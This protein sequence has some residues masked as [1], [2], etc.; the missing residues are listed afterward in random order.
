MKPF[1]PFIV[2]SLVLLA[3]W[4]IYAF[5]LVQ[6]PI[7]FPTPLAVLVRL[8]SEAPTISFHVAVTMAEA[9]SGFALSAVLAY[10]LA[11]AFYLSHSVRDGLYPYA[12]MLKATPLVAIA[13]IITLWLGDGPLSKIAMASI[14][15]FF[16]ILVA[17]YVGLQRF[18]EE[19]TMFFRGLGATRPYLLRRIIIPGSMPYLFSGLRIGS[20]LAVVGAVIAEFTGASSGI[21][22]LI[23]T[24]AY[25]LETDVVFAAIIALGLASVAF[26]GLIALIERKV[27][28]WEKINS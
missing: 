3:L 12:I 9:I 20:T 21:G 23:K 6:S 8:L 26:F 13:P 4:H 10:A 17:S 27:I 18:G 5:Y 11:L 28:F 22:Y 24:R 7:V 16:P 15:A 2:A 25:Y 19:E 14:V 1:A